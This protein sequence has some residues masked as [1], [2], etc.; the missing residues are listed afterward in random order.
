MARYVERRS[1][2]PG[3]LDSIHI[4]EDGSPSLPGNLSSRFECPV[5]RPSPGR[6]SLRGAS[7]LSR[8]SSPRDDLIPLGNLQKVWKLSH[9]SKFRCSVNNSR[10]PSCSQVVSHYY[11]RLA[12]CSTEG[13]RR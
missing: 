4:A 8:N 12:Y 3:V 2:H 9:A 11:C 10:K 7:I 6:G 13:T 5:A 1:G